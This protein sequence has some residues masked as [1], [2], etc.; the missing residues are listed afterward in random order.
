MNDWPHHASRNSTGF[1]HQ[2]INLECELVHTPPM[3][4]A[5]VEDPDPTGTLA[6]LDQVF[7]AI[8]PHNL[9]VG[10]RSGAADTPLRAL[11]D[12]TEFFSSR[13]KAWSS[14]AGLADGSLGSAL[15]FRMC[16]AR[17]ML[18]AGTTPMAA[19]LRHLLAD[20]AA[21]GWE[22]RAMPAILTPLHKLAAPLLSES[23]SNRFYN[24]LERSGFGYVEE[25]AAAPDEGILELRNGGQRLI[26]TV[27]KVV[28]ELVRESEALDRPV[29]P[30]VPYSGDRS[31]RLPVGVLQALQVV[32]AWAVLERG[33][34]TAVDLARIP[35]GEDELPSD[36]AD[37]WRQIGRLDLRLLAGP[38]T[39]ETRLPALA[40]E[41]LAE[42]EP[43]RR[44]ILTERTF[45]PQ[46]KTYSTLAAELD[47]TPERVRQLEVDALMKLGRT[48]TKEPYAPL[49]W[50]ALSVGNS[51]DTVSGTSSMTDLLLEWIAGR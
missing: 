25:V 12:L 49:R 24:M 45:S 26:E 5:T 22:L 9:D 3:L 21:P 35:V 15:V 50:R 20:G 42:I 23:G 43:R 29:D 47:V 48:V 32:A 36:V 13:P 18:V 40:A 34:Q 10:L 14:Y 19:E 51:Q 41:L 7:G 37:A 1:P 33:A 11:T 17:T 38:V 2:R 28:G 44:L 4:E 6:H 16:P 27:R 46:R 31:P 30:G 39:G 8:N